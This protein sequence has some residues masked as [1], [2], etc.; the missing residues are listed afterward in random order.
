MLTPGEVLDQAFLD[1]RSMLLEIAAT[2]DRYEDAVRRQQGI[3]GPT[4]R[5]DER[6]EMI[7]QAIAI[8]G[9]KLPERY[10]TEQILELFSVRED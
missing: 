5:P 6:L 4:D 8:L 10:R 9:Q 7:F 2:L 3:N 1:V